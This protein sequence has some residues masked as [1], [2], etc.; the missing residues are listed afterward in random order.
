MRIKP[1]KRTL[2]ATALTNPDPSFVSMVGGPANQTPFAVVRSDDTIEAPPAPETDMKLNRLKA[3]TSVTAIVAK[4]H[5]VMQ[6]QFDKGVFKSASDVETWLTAGGYEGYTVIEKASRF[7]VEDDATRFEVG[8]VVRIDAAD[9]LAAFVGKVAGY[10]AEDEAP[11]EEPPVAVVAE[12]EGTQKA[13]DI[14][15]PAR[16]RAVAAPVAEAEQPVAVI[17]AG[18]GTEDERASG[19][20]MSDDLVQRL[21][22][23]STAHPTSHVKKVSG[24]T[25]C[26]IVDVTRT[27][28]Y[29]VSD[30][31]YDG[32]ETSAVDA[33]K[34]AA[35]SSLEALTGVVAQYT[36]EMSNVFDGAVGVTKAQRSEA[37]PE[38]PASVEAPVAAVPD[39]AEIVRAAVAEATAP[40]A[41]QIEAA[42]A[43][44]TK[45]VDEAREA[46]ARA[47]QAERDL[48]E[49]V[50]ADAS[51]SQTRKG[52]DDL[53]T[54]APSAQPATR[55][56]AS[57]TM[58]S[59][60][61]SRHA[62]GG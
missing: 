42:T 39:V 12:P 50:E 54:P 22:A 61:G 9:G 45:A 28:R 47:E 18:N 51:R 10:S 30:A 32:I 33:L 49:R 48:A 46:V 31:D 8:S 29:L 56:R 34:A 21:D 7:E 44:S 17:P 15:P 5:G 55:C 26:S 6:F 40:M 14:D 27:L 25:I 58:L 62:N 59:A 37:E 24:Y 2:T 43:A 41:A 16:Q 60:F 11:A 13:V 23:I 3:S 4:G 36:T 35:I 53:D 20:V 1:I 52:A 38:A 57:Q 19:L